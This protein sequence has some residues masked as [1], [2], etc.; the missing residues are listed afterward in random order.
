M[1]PTTR[2]KHFEMKHI[3]EIEPEGMTLEQMRAAQEAYLKARNER[4][5][6][7]ATPE[8]EEK[9]LSYWKGVFAD[10]PRASATFTVVPRTA[11]EMD[12]Q[13][14]RRKFWAVL[15]M[16]A[17]HIIAVQGVEDFNFTFSPEQAQ[18]VAGLL[19]YF[20]NDPASPYELHKGIFIYSKPGTGKTE[21]MQAFSRFCEQY[22]LSKKFRI[23][24]MPEVYEEARS[25]KDVVELY[26]QHTTCFDE[27]ARVT[28]S[29]TVYGNPIDPNEAILE[30]RY[31]RRQRYGQITHL[32]AN[33]TPNDL[34]GEKSILSPA[35]QD[36][37]LEMFS[38]V[39]YPGES[40]R[41]KL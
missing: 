6:I 24:H 22:D 2:S 33:A 31:L 5:K 7:P 3:H 25:G 1:P 12:Y 26:L 23:V 13:D 41:R 16:R 30:A 28:G 20:I 35:L 34:V 10:R 11:Q 40:K 4:G 21:L 29:V 8:Q 17:A 37:I 14:A 32:I 27:F 39:F 9:L 19:R 18:V 38:G 36:R 15:Q